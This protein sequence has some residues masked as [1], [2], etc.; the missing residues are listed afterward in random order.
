[1]TRVIGSGMSRD[2]GEELR[3]GGDVLL[4][5]LVEVG[6]F[7]VGV[8]IAADFRDLLFVH[9]C[10]QPAPLAATEA[11]IMRFDNHLGWSNAGKFLL[12]REFRLGGTELCHG[13]FA[14]SAIDVSDA[15]VIASRDDTGQCQ[16][17]D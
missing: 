3:E 2:A 4:V 17:V 13:E 5:L 11:T 10:C 14:G 9:Y 7:G 8:T 1:M 12:E 15:N 6:D 16:T